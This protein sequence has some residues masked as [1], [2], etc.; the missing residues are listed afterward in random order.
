MINRCLIYGFRHYPS[1]PIPDEDSHEGA[2]ALIAVVGM[3]S[4]VDHV[5]LPLVQKVAVDRWDEEWKH[6]TL[7]AQAVA[8]AVTQERGADGET[9]RVL[10]VELHQIDLQPER[11][12]EPAPEQTREQAFYSR[13]KMA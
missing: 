10:E 3:A 5:S 6:I 11:P 8:V 9:D 7:S 1:G 12:D 2:L 4:K 13:S